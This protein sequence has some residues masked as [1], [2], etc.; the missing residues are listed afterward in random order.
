MVSV[1]KST[2]SACLDSACV[3]ISFIFFDNF[4][5]QSDLTSALTA[6]I[7]SLSVFFCSTVKQAFKGASCPLTILCVARQIHCVPNANSW[8]FKLVLAAQHFG[9]TASLSNT[10]LGQVCLSLLC[11]SVLTCRSILEIEL[12]N[13]HTYNL[14]ACSTA[15]CLP[16]T[17][18]L[19]TILRMLA[20]WYQLYPL[21]CSN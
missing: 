20:C 1:S 18:I 8:C 15:P 9:A 13:V 3:S 11:V 14:S 7:E 2:T 5:L 4:C 10:S 12:R 6:D 19:F 17:P 16:F 21:H